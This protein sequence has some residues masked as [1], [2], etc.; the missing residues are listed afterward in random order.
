M[1]NENLTA[2]EA[3]RQRQRRTFRTIT[4]TAAAALVVGMGAGIWI[5][6][7]MGR[8]ATYTAHPVTEPAPRNKPRVVGTARGWR[9]AYLNDHDEFRSREDGTRLPVVTFWMDPEKQP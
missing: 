8:K 2:R 1:S 6:S 4:I 3:R 9:Y 5:H 7:T